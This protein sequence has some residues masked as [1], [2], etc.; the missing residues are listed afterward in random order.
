MPH[1]RRSR[2][3]RRVLAAV[4]AVGV[5]TSGCVNLDEMEFVKDERLTFTAPDDYEQVEV[6]LT[7]TWTMED[8]EV[9]PRPE[10]GAE[11]SEPSKGEGYYAVFVDKAPVKPGHTLD[12]V[13]NGDTFCESDPRCP[14]KSYLNAKG[15]YTTRQP[16]ITLD[17]VA[18]LSSKERLQLHTLTVILLD[19]EGK[20][21]GEYA[22]FT[23]FRLENKVLD[24]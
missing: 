7:V 24:L 13:G 1:L 11:R 3:P 18:P 10:K 2:R 20:R 12:D 8:F 23:R 15:V 5:L 6:P 21:I 4:L 9:L 17:V 19:S 22:W 16:T 14:D